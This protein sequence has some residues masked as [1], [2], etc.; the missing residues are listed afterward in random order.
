MNQ[1]KT[2]NLKLNNIEFLCLK[3]AAHPGMSGRWYLR[4]LHRYRFG[5]PGTGGWNA[6]YLSPC[7]RYRNVL[8]LNTAP[9]DRPGSI[10]HRRC[11]KVGQFQLTPAGKTVARLA[12]E[13]IGATL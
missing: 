1:V 10:D 5:T 13:K 12:A 9:A 2:P 11:S 7:G 8:F 3:M 6:L 4:E